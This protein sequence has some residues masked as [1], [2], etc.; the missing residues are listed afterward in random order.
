[1]GSHQ[2]LP[3]QTL[4]DS[5]Q[6]YHCPQDLAKTAH[7]AEVNSFRRIRHSHPIRH[8]KFMFSAV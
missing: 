2:E 4:M 3:H 1:M 5:I 8:V 7:Q 6:K